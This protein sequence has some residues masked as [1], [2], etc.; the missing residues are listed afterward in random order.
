MGLRHGE[1]IG[2]FA[3][4]FTYVL[5]DGIEV[6]QVSNRTHMSYSRLIL[7]A[8]RFT[9]DHNF[10]AYEILIDGIPLL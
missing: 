9:P 8:E 5:L 6:G 10:M 7:D 2:L 4:S 1:T 3:T